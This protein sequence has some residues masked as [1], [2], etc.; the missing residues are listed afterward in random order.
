MMV[1]PLNWNN[2]IALSLLLGITG[3][4]QPVVAQT[5]AN[6]AGSGTTA[7]VYNPSS[8]T[9]G[10]TTAPVYNPS[11]GSSTNISGSLNN[12]E[13]MGGQLSGTTN[14]I[15]NAAQGIFQQIQGMYQQIGGILQR[16]LGSVS[17]E[18]GK[19]LTDILGA[20]NLPDP[21]ELL[22]RILQDSNSDTIANNN[23]AGISPVILRDNQ[24]ATIAAKIFVQQNFSQEAQQNARK[25]LEWIAS[26]V[27]NAGQFSTASGQ[28]AQQAAQAAT[29]AGQAA[30][31]AQQTAT[32]AQNRVSTQ[33]ALKDLNIIAGQLSS[34]LSSLASQSAAQSGQ[35]T[36]LTQ[37]EAMNTQITG[38]SSAKLTQ[39]NQGIA[40][41]VQQLADLNSQMRGKE[42]Q[43]AMRHT[44]TLDN[45]QM[46]NSRAYRLLH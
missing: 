17:G 2:K 16:V 41:S 45:L 24:T 31:T 46:V 10:T 1:F 30:Q 21:Q 34:Q 42:Q 27:Q 39:I 13:A 32:Q 14:Q 28:L 19:V 12:L 26:Q 22:D 23:I 33:D 8:G 25:D 3:I 18:M 9:T 43:E 40:A 6:T 29:Q 44:A 7:P 38:A 36:N 20:M 11:S 5:Y 15:I 35:L 37:L 4:T